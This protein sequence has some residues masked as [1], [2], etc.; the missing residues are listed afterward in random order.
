M[1]QHVNHST[2]LNAIIGY[3]L[4]HTQ[5]PVLHNTIYNALNINS[6]LMA[7][8]HP[9][10]SR[11]ID[12]IKTLNI[13]LTAVTM[14]HKEAVI[15]YLDHCSETVTALQAA[16]TIIQK[17]GEL[18]GYNTDV[19]GIEYALRQTNLTQKNVLVI[20]AG[21]AARAMGY[22]LQ[23]HQANIYWLNRTPSK[24]Q[25]LI[26]A[27]GGQA[28]D[29]RD[30]DNLPIDII[31]NTTPLGMYPEIHHS[32]LPNKFL[33]HHQTVFDM[34]YNPLETQLLNEAKAA[35]AKTI[36]GM[37]MFIAQGIKQIS[38]WQGKELYTPEL[39]QLV[40]DAIRIETG[41]AV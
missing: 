28:I 16:N 20:G 18:W 5:S 6:L 19:D 4:T 23:K 38:L 26:N 34:I 12:A 8:P 17:N 13:G 39:E 7:F 9:D 40:R 27:F 21:G 35:G 11:L 31:I 32:P 33:R 14:P 24:A 10:L 41:K 36:S 2:T 25:A 22:V 15:P 1:S 30:L 3:P 29:Q 37:D